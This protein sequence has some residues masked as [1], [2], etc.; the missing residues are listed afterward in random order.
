MAR[1]H[2]RTIASSRRGSPLVAGQIVLAGHQIEVVGLDAVGAA[3]LDGLLLFRQQLELQG[4][5]D[6]LA[7]LVL[8]GEDVGQVAVVA[9]GPDV[10]AGARRRSAGR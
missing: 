2:R 8:Q 5:D 10:V 9:L 6:G 1:R 7:D 4:L 3:P